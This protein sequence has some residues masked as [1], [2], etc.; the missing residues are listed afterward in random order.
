M[1]ARQ[2]GA[3]E[4][5]VARAREADVAPAPEVPVTAGWT[6]A[7]PSA[8]GAGAFALTTFVL[9]VFNTGLVGISNRV[10]CSGSC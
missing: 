10:R 2:V 3:R 9:S 1:E 8:L 7:N 4:G 6:P 5:E